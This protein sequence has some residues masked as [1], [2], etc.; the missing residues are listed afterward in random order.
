LSHA[1]AFLRAKGISKLSPA[2]ELEI[3]AQSSG[4]SAQASTPDESLTE[5]ESE[6]AEEGGS[7]E[8]TASR[9]ENQSKSEEGDDKS[10]R[11]SENEH[12]RGRS[13]ESKGQQP[14]EK[15]LSKPIS[16]NPN[17]EQGISKGLHLG[18]R[19]G[20]S[21]QS[22]PNGS[23]SSGTK[24][25]TKSLTKP[26]AE[27]G[28][29]SRLL[30]YAEPSASNNVPHRDEDPLEQARRDEI[31]RSAVSYFMATQSKGWKSLEEMP[32]NNPGFDVKGVSFKGVE[33]FIEVK[34]QSGAWSEVGV[35]ITPRELQH[36]FENR[37]RYW[38]CVVEYALDE[39]RRNLFLV[40]DPFGQTDQFRY[41]SGWKDIAVKAPSIQLK[42]EPGLFVEILGEGKGKILSV[43]KAAQFFKL[44]VVLPGNRQL[45]KTFNPQTMTLS[46]E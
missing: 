17:K 32:P 28:K 13:P 23:K 7:E 34:G 5:G 26:F 6:S 37:D 9:T 21:S 25:G 22:S 40:K 31:S 38:L 1:E 2:D 33:E 36:A 42:P 16:S 18:S 3:A 29:H 27:N 24:Q 8:K 39:N 45:F 11:D 4:S 20:A 44:H 14:Q 19:T 30:S 46:T 35:A 15:Q 41:D 12:A 10:N 43:K